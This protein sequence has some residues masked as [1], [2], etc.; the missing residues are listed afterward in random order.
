[1]ICSLTALKNKLWKN[2]F[3][4]YMKRERN[5]SNVTFVTKVFLKKAI[6]QNTLLLST[7]LTNRSNVIFVT[8]FFCKEQFKE[9]YCWW[10]WKE[11]K[12]WMPLCNQKISLQKNLRKHSSE[13]HEVKKP[14]KCDICDYCF[15]Q[16]GSLKIHMLP[17][18]DENK[19]FKCELVITVLLQGQF[20]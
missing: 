6:C 18:H 10:S 16:N 19:T 9:T 11:E 7:I 1:M 17:V 3:L 13:I 12:I 4:K 8:K 2:I 14:L 15:C 20:D 5:R